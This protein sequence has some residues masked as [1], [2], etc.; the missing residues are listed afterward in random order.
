MM[1]ITAHAAR[2]QT[3][4]ATFRHQFE[5]GACF[6][7]GTLVHTKEGLTPIEQIKAGYW[8]LSKPENGGEQAYKRVLQTF[9][10]KP[11][12]VVRLAY[13]IPE[14][15]PNKFG[16]TVG[17][18]T[19]TLNHPFWIEECGWTSVPELEKKDIKS[20]NFNDVDGNKT[21]FW[22]VT[23]V[24]V[25]EQ[26]H[27]GWI[28]M[29][30]GATD[31]LGALWDYENHKLVD[32]EILAIDA[33]SQTYQ[34]LKDYKQRIDPSLFF[35]APVYSLEVEEFRTYYVGEHG[36]WVH[37]HNCGGHDLMVQPAND[38]GS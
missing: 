37:N 15:K 8:V 34:D 20:V 12:R 2:L 10:H 22:D 9:A 30:M 38:I 17:V 35:K 16:S 25:S 19:C 4:N 13:C 7:K 1:Q 21:P 32:A 26:P 6:A 36:I 28:P 5:P 33:V 31:S 24:Y 29:N 27:V 23:N 3:P 18:I 14:A 11:E